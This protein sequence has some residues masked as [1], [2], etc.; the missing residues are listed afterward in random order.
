MSAVQHQPNQ[1]LQPFNTM[2]QR[3]VINNT[4]TAGLTVKLS[5]GKA[6]KQFCQILVAFLLASLL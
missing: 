3:I 2:Q 5:W 4:T 1:T 6:Y